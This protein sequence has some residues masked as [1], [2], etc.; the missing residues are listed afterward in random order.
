[1][2]YFYEFKNILRR[3]SIAFISP[4]GFKAHTKNFRTSGL[5]LMLFSTFRE[6]EIQVNCGCWKIEVRERI[7]GA[8]IFCLTGVKWYSQVTH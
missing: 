5:E 8:N 4:K 3:D 7:F 1:M 2:F 6:S